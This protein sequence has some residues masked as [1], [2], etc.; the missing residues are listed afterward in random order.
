VTTRHKFKAIPSGSF[1]DQYVQITITI[2]E[3]DRTDVDTLAVPVGSAPGLQPKVVEVATHKPLE[4]VLLS[5]TSELQVTVTNVGTMPVSVQRLSVDPE[6][7]DLWIEP[8]VFDGIVTPFDL[9]PQS[10]LTFKLVAKPHTRRAMGMSWPPTDNNQRHTTFS[11][12]ALYVNPLFQNRSGQTSLSV[13]IRFQPNLLSLALAL[14]L[15]VL[16]GTLV[17]WLTQKAHWRGRL[18]AFATALLVGMILE[19]VGMF[20]VAK[21]SKFV[22][23]GYN[24]DPWQSLPVVLLGTGVGLLGLKSAEQL[25]GF[26]RGRGNAN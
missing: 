20:L 5:G 15:G 16:L 14:V 21:D 17:L 11:V 22:L 8:P 25:S 24:L 19:M 4:S 10:P 3:G 9:A 23:F 2:K 26:F 1:P 6:Q 18:Q 13:P 7:N 12:A